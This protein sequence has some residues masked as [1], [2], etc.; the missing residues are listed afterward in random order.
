MGHGESI[1][2]IA[3]PTPKSGIGGMKGEISQKVLDHSLFA[4]ITCFQMKEDGPGA[5]RNQGDR[6]HWSL[7][8]AGSK[9]QASNTY[10]GFLR[11]ETAGKK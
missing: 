11:R 10:L 6:P 3:F 1:K 4:K 5:L 7:S 9:S 8:H 2:Y